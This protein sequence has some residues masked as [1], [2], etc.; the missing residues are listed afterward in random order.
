[1]RPRLREL[2]LVRFAYAGAVVARVLLGYKLLALRKGRWSPEKYQH[3]LSV[4]HLNSARRIYN[5]VLRL[6]GLM[7]KIG[8]TLG[9]R[10]DMLPE[11]YIRVLS[12]LQDQVPPRP[13]NK[14]RPHIERQL[15]A[16]LGDVFSEFDAEPVAAASLAQVY[17]ASLKDGRDVAVKVV[18]PGIERLVD[19]DL[20]ILRAI[21]W[22]ESR[23]DPQPVEPIYRELAANIPFEVDM[24]HEAESMEALASKLAHRQEIVIPGV[25]WEH[26]RKRVL[27]ME[28]IDGIKITDLPRLT[29][30]GTDID[31]LF[32]LVADVYSEQ[33]LRIGHFQA[34]PH[35]GNLFALPGNRLAILDFGLTKRFTPEFQAAFKAMARGIFGGDA[36]GAEEAMR[37][38]GFTFRREGADGFVAIGEL[39]RGATDP[40]T[41]RDPELLKA[42]YDGS[43]RTTKQNPLV[44]MPGEIT[45]ALRV[46]GLVMGLVV[47]SKADVDLGQALLRYAEE[48]PDDTSRIASTRGRLPDGVE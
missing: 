33:M 36:G 22:I 40:N 12:P 31:E 44:D 23:I 47:A 45:L 14:M 18:Y 41:Y 17:R 37:A 5:G 19:T 32:R 26:T 15:G 39:F 13:F 6:Q 24:I 7:I 21:F 29:Q 27:T 43:L 9:S 3:R 10:P 48:P 4:Y 42:V 1:M 34:D 2:R 38:A 16:R 28:Y 46:L 35:P 20:R 25:I 11:E 8:Q 30:A